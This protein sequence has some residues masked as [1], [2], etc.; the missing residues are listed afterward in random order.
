MRIPIFQRAAKTPWAI[1]EDYLQTILDI[2]QRNTESPEAVAAKLGRQLENTY[3]V[4]Y[5]EGV[6]ILNIQGP[7]F[8]YANLF[9]EI[10]GATSF[11]MLAQDF[12]AAVEDPAVRAILLN[13]DSPGGEA[14]GNNELAEMIYQA[15]GTKPIVAYIGGMGASAAYWISSAADRIV[16]DQTALIGSIG[17]RTALIDDSK[18]MEDAGLKEYVIVSS[19]SPYKHTD[20][21]DADDRGRIQTIIDDLASVFVAKVARNRGVSEDTV[22]SDFGQGDVMVASKAVD[23]GLIDG[24]GSF[25]SVLAELAAPQQEELFSTSAPA[26]VGHSTRKEGHMYL[27]NEAPAAGEEQRQFEATADNITRLCPEAA[28]ALRAEG[29]QRVEVP[30]AAAAVTAER[31]RVAGIINCEEAQ[32][33]EGLAQ[34]LALTEGMTVESAQ[35][36]LA[37]QPKAKAGQSWLASMQGADVDVGADGPGGD[38]DSPEKVAQAAVQSARESGYIR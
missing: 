27:T 36:I 22:L 29:E 24:L 21:A 38:T 18:A 10:S 23:A 1:T 31:E 8:R 12:T 7:L 28:E 17:V 11:E 14:N 3:D 20:P 6:A 32:G 16:A 2:A 35:R 33:R 15:R 34:Q 5:R 4:E 19:Q 30:D 25:E 9:T 26:A 13:V 37:A